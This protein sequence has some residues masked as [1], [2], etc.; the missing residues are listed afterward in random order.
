[1][2]RLMLILRGRSHRL[3]AS[4]ATPE[5]SS[6]RPDDLIVEAGQCCATMRHHLANSCSSHACDCPDEIVK[7]YRGNREGEAVI[8][9]IPIHDGGRS[10]VAIRYCPW[11]GAR[12]G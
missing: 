10:F 8:V 11:C 3:F 2:T 9:G 12:T 5:E 6:R 4:P 1:M 7:L